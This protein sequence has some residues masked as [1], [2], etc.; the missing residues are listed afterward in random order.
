MTISIEN[1]ILLVLIGLYLWHAGTLYRTVTD[2]L[3]ALIEKQ[4]EKTGR[5]LNKLEMFFVW[6]IVIFACLFWPITMLR[7]LFRYYKRYKN[8]NRKDD[9]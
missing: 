4:E 9:E 8:M 5:N 6:C 3:P 1:L 7:G 2:A